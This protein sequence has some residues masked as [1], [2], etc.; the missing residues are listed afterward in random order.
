[1]NLKSLI[2]G[3]KRTKSNIKKRLRE[4]DKLREKREKDIFSELA[5]CIFT[6]GS[7]AV[8]CAQ[9]VNCLKGSGLIFNG[10]KGEIS[11]V[12]RGLVRFHNNKAAYLVDA[13]KSFTKSK[14]IGKSN[15]EARE[16]LVKNI[17]GLGYKEASHFLRN[18]GLGGDMAILD[19]HIL[20]NLKKYQ[21]IDEI[22]KPPI[23]KTAYLAI[24]DK[25]RKFSKR[26]KVSLSELDL[27]FWSSQTGF[28][29]K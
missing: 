10:S 23:N 8:N 13:R 16:W 1:M 4:F 3:Y 7:K 9:A 28:I 19:R 14:I 27:L 29:F 26:I 21:V 5:F 11:K 25:M 18:I 22:P 17:K 20:K 15:F 12:L 6:P 24:E 2:S